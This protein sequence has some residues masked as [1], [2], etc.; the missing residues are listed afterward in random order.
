MK[1]SLNNNIQVNSINSLIK[2]LESYDKRHGWRGPYLENIDLKK[3]ES[4]ILKEK[5]NYRNKQLALVTNVE[6][7]AINI[8]TDNKTNTNLV[9]NNFKWARRYISADARGPN[10][11]NAHE[12]VKKGDVVFV[13][14]IKKNE[15]KL[16]QIPNVNGGVI[17][18]LLYTSPSPRD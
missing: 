3:F 10:I 11:K 8:L 15:Y 12:I 1:T 5:G 4:L 9:F 7:K 16:D 14:I 13:S 18:C 2:N 17:V 6:D